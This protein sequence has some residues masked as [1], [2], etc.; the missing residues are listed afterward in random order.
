MYWRS[1]R[2]D[3]VPALAKLRQGHS[4]LWICCDGRDC[5]RSAAVDLT[6]FIIRWGE[7]ASSNVLRRNAQCQYCGTKGV[8]IQLP[9]W[10]GENNT[11][12]PFPV[13]RMSPW[14]KL[15]SEASPTDPGSAPS[16]RA[17]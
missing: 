15:I 9:G 6:P 4:W 5:A 12:A 14:P 1:Y 11:E 2:D 7:D 17:P 10:F 3:Q 16:S 8:T 13:D